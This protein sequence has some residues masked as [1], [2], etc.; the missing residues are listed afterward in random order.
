[1]TLRVDGLAC[2]RGGEA[3]VAGLSFA[4]GPGAALILRG[5]NGAGK[6]TLLRCLAG[7]APPLAGTVTM[8]EGGA[9][10]ASH[11]DGAKAA[12]S[13]TENLRFWADL[14]GRPWDDAIL[15]AF[16]LNALRDRRAGTLS[17]GQ[18]RRRGLARLA[19]TGRPVLLLDEPTTALD[20]ASAARFMG[21][22][23]G[24]L[25]RGGLAVIAAH[26][27]VDLDAPDLDLASFRAAPTG[28]EA[29]L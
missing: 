14:H 25:A 3:V 29:F 1:M 27:P 5:P 11:L 2:A 7:L 9:A 13:V 26:G 18:S 12:L 23:S 8:P 6:T 22:L 20:A 16:D 10:Y 28:D 24:H 4:V 15:D 19:L 21:W 17:A